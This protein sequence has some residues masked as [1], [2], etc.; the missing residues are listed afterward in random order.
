MFLFFSLILFINSKTGK[1]YDLKQFSKSQE[2]NSR[3]YEMI[4]K[5]FKEE[6]IK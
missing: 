6:I 5:F 1:E 4:N 3:E 2:P